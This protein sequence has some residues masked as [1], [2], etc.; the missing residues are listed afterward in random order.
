MSIVKFSSAIKQIRLS[1]VKISVN[2]MSTST[3]EVK[4]A[5]NSSNSSNIVTDPNCIFC[6][7]RD[8]TVPANILYED[9]K[10]VVF[11]DHKPA[12]ENHLLVI[13]RTHIKNISVLKSSDETMVQEMLETG[14]KTL[15]ESVSDINTEDLRTG[16]H[17]PIHTVS[18]LHMHIIYPPP[19]GL[20]SRIIF[21]SWFFKSTEQVLESLKSK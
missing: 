12:S 11:P 4:S 17:W 3:E 13:P 15:R 20:I 14:L 6:K 8:K 16:F 21:S 1:G 7:I 10:Y 5:E 2:T 18:H 9:D 19:Q